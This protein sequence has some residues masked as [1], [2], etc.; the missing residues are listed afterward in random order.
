MGQEH[1]GVKVRILDE[2]PHAHR[3]GRHVEHHEASR[4]FAAVHTVIRT[5]AHV[6]H[7]PAFE[8]GELGSCTGNAMAGALM[9]EPLYVPGRTLVED[10][11]VRLYAK[12]T[13]LDQVPG[14]Y[15]PDDTG[16]SGLAVAK[17]AKEEGLIVSY[18]HAF[19]LNAALAALSQGPVIVGTEW[20]EGFD[21]P[22]LIEDPSNG[23]ILEAEIFAS[24]SSRGG[25]EYVLDRI[26]VGLR[27]VHFTNS[28]GVTWGKD[29]GAYMS[30][31]LLAELLKNDGDV[32]VPNR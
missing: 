28:W 20:L 19:T 18:H 7:C 16:S 29:G 31:D 21:E 22:R 11:A 12:A 2:R 8:Q 6:R 15:P 17:A 9:T 26:D 13:H 32:V 24:G 3:L 25:H 1:P 27:R 14:A 4:Q 23:S 10:D 30:F 5:A